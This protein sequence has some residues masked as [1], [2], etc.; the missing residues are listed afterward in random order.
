[1]KNK[2]NLKNILLKIDTEEGGGGEVEYPVLI[3]TKRN[4]FFVYK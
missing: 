1:M 2:I 3:G 4:I